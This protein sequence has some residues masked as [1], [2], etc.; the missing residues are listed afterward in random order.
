MSPQ[1]DRCRGCGA[2]IAF[3]KTVKGKT[4]PVDPDPVDFVPDTAGRALYVTADG[5]VLH[6]APPSD[7]DPDVHQG[8]ISHFA[9]CPRA[10]D[11]RR[12]R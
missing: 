6:G 11:F 3:I 1:T 2:P 9:T 5:L 10:A 7:A 8:W 4:M 12:R